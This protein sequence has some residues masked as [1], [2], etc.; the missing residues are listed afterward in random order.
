MNEAWRQ[1]L[2]LNWDRLVAGGRVEVPPSLPNPSLAGFSRPW[3]SEDGG[4]LIDWTL[5]LADGSR[6]HAHEYGDGGIVIHRDEI[7]PKG[8]FSG[9]WHVLT[10]THFGSLVLRAGAIAVGIYVG[11]KLGG[12]WG[13]AIGGAT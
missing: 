7:D 3:I 1:F 2:V 8:L 11:S 13:N 9:P 12:T 10:E 5:S 4:Q 6:I